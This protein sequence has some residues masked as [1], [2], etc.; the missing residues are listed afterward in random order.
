MSEYRRGPSEPVFQICCFM[1]STELPSVIYYE[2]GY[3]IMVHSD[4]QEAGTGR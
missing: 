1:I 2:P 4:T 3:R